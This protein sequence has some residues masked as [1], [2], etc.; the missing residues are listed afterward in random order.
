[1][2]FVEN[3]SNKSEAYRDTFKQ[4]YTTLQNTVR[5]LLKQ[6]DRRKWTCDKSNQLCK[7]LVLVSFI[8]T[9]MYTINKMVIFAIEIQKNH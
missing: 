7:L 4:K 6:A 9:K 2:V 3:F 8:K 1:M 5:T